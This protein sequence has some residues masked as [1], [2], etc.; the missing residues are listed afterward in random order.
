MRA[1]HTASIGG[2][3]DKS[4][5]DVAGLER[6]EVLALVEVPEHCDTVLAS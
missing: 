5:D 2:R 3:E 1:Q 4:I 6:I